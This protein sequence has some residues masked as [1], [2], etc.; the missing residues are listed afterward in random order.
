VSSLIP[1]EGSL[2]VQEGWASARDA[3]VTATVGVAFV[4]GVAEL[5]AAGV[6]AARLD[7][8]VLLGCALKI[9]KEEIIRNPD[10]LIPPAPLSLYRKFLARRCSGEPTAY[11]T[12]KKEFWSMEFVVGPGVLIPRPETEILVEETIRLVAESPEMTEG[13]RCLEIGAGSGAIAVALAREIRQAEIVSVDSSRTALGYARE[14]AQ[15]HGVSDRIAYVCT[16]QTG[17]FAPD[18]GVF[19]LIVSNPPYVESSQLPMLQREIIDHE[20]H[21]ALDGGPD[22]LDFYRKIVQA[23]PG[24][25]APGGRLCLEIGAG[26]AK[27]VT[28]LLKESKRFDRIETRNDHASNPRV[29]TARMQRLED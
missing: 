11:I 2:V 6:E 15:T 29:V 18:A 4:Q 7:A 16:D 8:E 5:R 13:L 23:S 10:T 12:G 24:L 14:N 27:D 17:P 26:Q 19:D 3:D 28:A 22:G 21:A 20:P 9:S 1:N 25:L